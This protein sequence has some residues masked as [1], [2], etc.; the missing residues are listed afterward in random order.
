MTDSNPLSQTTADPELTTPVQYLKGVGP[1]RGEL[2]RRL[3]LRIARDV[4]FFF[5][6]DYQSLGE[7]ISIG[8]LEEGQPACIQGVVDE[9][10]LRELGGGR[11]MLGVLVRQETHFLRAVWFNQPFLR[12]RFRLGQPVRLSGPP[13]RRGLRWEMSHPRIAFPGLESSPDASGPVPVYRLTEGLRQHQLRRLVAQV[14]ATHA[15]AVDEVFPEAYLA[16]HQLPGIQEAL[17][18]IHN[19]PSEA[20]LDQ[21][22][23]R[24][25][26]QELLVLQLALALRRAR[27]LHQCQAPV[28]EATAKI[29]ARIRRLFPFELTEQQETAVQE[30]SRDMG[31][32]HP[33]N[34]LLQGDV[35]SGKTVVAEYAMLL[36]V[37]HDYQAVMMAPTEVL[38]RQ[39]AHTLQRDLSESRVRIGILTGSL[40]AAERRQTLEHIADGRINLVVGTHAVV[41]EDVR[42]QRLGLVVIDE[43]H[44]F[45]VR[46]RALLRQSGLDPHYLVMTATPIPRT[47]SMTLFGDLDFSTLRQGP[48]GRQP[49]HTYVA[50]P[51]QRAKWW[52]FFRKKLLQ[53]R[54]GYVI[55]PLIDE[56]ETLALAGVRQTLDRL[57]EGELAGFEMGLIHGGMSPD[58]KA[59][60]MQ[61]FRRGETRVLVATSVIEVGVDVPNATL[62]AIEDGQ[63]FGLSQLHQLRGRISRGT[64]PGY[65]CVFADAQTPE[66]RQRLDAL[67]ATNDGFALAETD[68]QLR[69]PGELLGT[70]QHG[71]PPLR[72][73]DLHRDRPLLEEARR[74]AQ[75]LVGADPDLADPRWE[76]LRRMVLRRYGAALELGDVG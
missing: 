71:L 52:E 68:F 61:K 27:L 41:Q 29:D 23:R 74:D 47:I 45:G 48:P 10:E 11:S 22:R 59:D 28:L 54:Q 38:A 76:R 39:H 5:P 12:E 7:P 2:L 19:P 60:A 42:F 30:I 49:V 69:G 64:F 8:L 50:E 21:A 70:R 33:M 9:V 4:L 51:G 1:S 26:Y 72:I 65:L 46:Q 6:R 43:Q 57:R 25:I 67:V 58:E 63:R 31:G 32:G 66:A 75:L 73:A 15:R 24:F 37:A 34:R 13:R 40:P 20:A 36:T 62:M 3:G 56:N 17:R 18:D 53:G 16:E 14:V 35:G 44:K 55:A